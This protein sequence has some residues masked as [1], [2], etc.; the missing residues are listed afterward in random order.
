MKILLPI[1]ITL[2]IFLSH[3]VSSATVENHIK[4][5]TINCSYECTEII[6]LNAG[7]H[8]VAKNSNGDVEKVIPVDDIPINAKRVMN[9]NG[10]IN[11][12]SSVP[13]VGITSTFYETPT[14]IVVVYITTYRDADGNLLDVQVTTVRIPKDTS[15]MPK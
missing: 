3:T 8:V 10:M 7:W 6:K 4:N 13:G 9:N 1:C 11:T 14:E 15:T 5:K 2:S 12:L